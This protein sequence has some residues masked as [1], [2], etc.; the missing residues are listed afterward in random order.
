MPGAPYGFNGQI[1]HA[2]LGSIYVTVGSIQRNVSINTSQD[3][4]SQAKTMYPLWVSQGGTALRLLHKDHAARDK[5]N[6]WVERFLN[7]SSSARLSHNWVDVSVPNHRFRR[8]AMIQGTLEYGE[9]VGD[10]LL[11]TTLSLVGAADPVRR[12]TE[13]SRMQM[14]DRDVVAVYFY[15][16]GVQAGWDTAEQ[17]YDIPPI[18]PGQG[19]RPV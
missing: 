12:Y 15:P 13:R 3:S 9:T 6:R 1:T 14:P 11:T 18:R 16:A 10:G 5:V 8:R 2:T 19:D 4:A 17:V 7:R